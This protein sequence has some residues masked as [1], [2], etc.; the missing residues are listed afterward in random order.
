MVEFNRRVVQRGL[1]S[2]ELRPTCARGR[3]SFRLW[4]MVFYDVHVWL[5]RNN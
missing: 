5:V 2:T 3:F 4:S 1:T